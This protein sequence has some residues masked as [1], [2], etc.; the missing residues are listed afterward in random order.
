MLLNIRARP[1]DDDL[2][3]L[4]PVS[5]ANDLSCHLEQHRTNTNKKTVPLDL[6]SK[7]EPMQRNGKEWEALQ[8][9][10]GDRAG[11]WTD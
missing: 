3:S 11:G 4:F 9:K 10:T 6:H 8:H 2:S 1:I 5:N 7:G